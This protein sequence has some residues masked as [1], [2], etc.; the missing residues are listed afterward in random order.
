MKKILIVDDEESVRQVIEATFRYMGT[1]NYITYCCNNGKEAF[2][3]LNVFRP[4]LVITDLQMPVMDG[5]ELTQKIKKEMP[6]LP[7]VILTGRPKLVPH[8]SP[9]DMVIEKPYLITEF[10]EK[11]RKLI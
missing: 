4:D 10:L 9:A 2:S 1:D 6:N 11:V 3:I 7:V 5:L 8:D